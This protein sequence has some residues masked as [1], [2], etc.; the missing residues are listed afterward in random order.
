MS[1]WSFG[2]EMGLFHFKN[3]KTHHTGIPLPYGKTN[4]DIF[5]NSIRLMKLQIKAV[6]N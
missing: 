6:K 5:I 3:Y 2:G 4:T 1:P